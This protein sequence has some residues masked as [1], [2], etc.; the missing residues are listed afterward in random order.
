MSG[1]IYDSSAI[2]RIDSL[3][4]QQEEELNKIDKEQDTKKIIRYGV[5]LGISALAIIVLKLVVKN[6]KK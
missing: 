3:L 6:R 1:L 4:N 5:I 2:T